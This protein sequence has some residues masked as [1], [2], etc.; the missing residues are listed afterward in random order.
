MVLK[1][2]LHGIK[3]PFHSNFPEVNLRFY[4]RYRSGSDW[5]RGVVFINEFVPKPAIAFVANRFY[6]ERFVTHPIKY[7]CET[8]DKLVIGYYWKKDSKWNKLEVIA[9]PKL[10]ELKPGSKEEFVIERY[11]GYSSIDKNKTEEFQVE[12]PQWNIYSIEHYNIDCDFKDLYGNDFEILDH[13]TPA[14]VFL[15]EGSAATIFSKK[16]L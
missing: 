4:V 10:Y 6:K 11:W 3:I 13:S 9:D 5:K 15:A 16:I 12:H 2:K 7:K 8:G 14:S 1:T